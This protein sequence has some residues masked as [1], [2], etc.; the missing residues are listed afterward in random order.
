VAGGQAHADLTV[1]HRPTGHAFATELDLAG[2]QL[3]R[4]AQTIPAWRD[5]PIRGTASAHAVLTGDWAARA[6]WR[7][8]GWLNASGEHLGEV[9]LLQK[10]FRGI[11]GLLG[12]R[13]G[14]ESLRRAQVTQASVTWRLS[15]ER[16]A[17]DDLRLGGLAGTDPVAVYAR[18][19]VGL[20][21]TLDFVIEPELAEGTLLQA[22]A[23]ATFAG[24]ILKAAGQF[25][26]FRRLVG[27]HRLT[28]TL[29]EPNYRFE[30]SVQ[31]TAAQLVPAAGE[32]LQGLLDFLGGR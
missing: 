1:E 8:S 3:E 7:G 12:E 32:A 2:L 4:L 6:S 18:G 14:L 17:T 15:Q 9:P 25:E 31:E 23:T 20:D 27:R 13:L 29:K 11:F 10:V 19:S 16:V 24:T 30:Y 21:Q 26:R 5:R 22:P 28:G